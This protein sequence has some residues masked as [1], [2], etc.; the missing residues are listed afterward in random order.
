MRVR[1]PALLLAAWLAAWLPG[2]AAAEPPSDTT[3]L[4]TDEIRA[5]FAGNTLYAE[6]LLERFADEPVRDFVIHLRADGDLTIRNLDGN[7]DT[8]RWQVTDEGLFCNQY[9]HTRRG[10]RKCY[11]V[12]EA[13]DGS[14]RMWDIEDEKY[15]MAFTIEAGNPEAL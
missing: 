6:T 13:A 15:S 8:G 7:T 3:A 10:I 11:E 1:L 14:Y 4:E 9:R 5:L 2:A 12:R